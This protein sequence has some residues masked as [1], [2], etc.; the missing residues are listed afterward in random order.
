[1]KYMGSKARIAKDI[2]PIMTAN[3]EK[4]QYFVSLFAGG[5][6]L[7][8][9]VDGKR[10]ANDSNPY[11]IAMWQELTSNTDSMIKTIDKS[12]YDMARM[13]YNNNKKYNHLLCPPIVMA[14]IG[15]VGFMA[16]YNGR[17]FDGGYS[18]N[19]K[20]RDYI[21]EQ[22]RNTLKQLPALKDVKLECKDYKDLDIPPKSIIYGDKPY[23]G[24]KQYNN[25]KDFNH[26][27]FWEWCRIMADNGHQVFVSE[28]N[29]PRDFKCIWSKEVTTTINHS[30]TKR[31]I[32]KLFTTNNKS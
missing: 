25:S 3:R 10:I 21:S 20:K 14:H 17:F 6:N 18:G 26:E 29:A 13:N 15:W 1:M 30:C 31:P 4:G 7:I 8:D 22:I 32:E 27:E 24:T 9:K 23:S 19:Y 16:S 11:L 5:M 28:Y 12:D 2:I